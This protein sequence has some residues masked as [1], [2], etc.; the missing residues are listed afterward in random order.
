MYFQNIETIEEIYFTPREIDIISCITNVRGIKKI[1]QILSISPRTVEGHIQNILL[2]ISSNS[3]ESIK[4]FIEKSEE[5]PLVKQHYLDLIINSF[6]E[7]QLNKLIPLFREAKI[8]CIVNHAQR[9]DILNYIIKYLKRVGIETIIDTSNDNFPITTQDKCTILVLNQN[10]ILELKKNKNYKNIIF[11]CTEEG[12]NYNVLH[13]FSD[14]QVL[15]FTTK[16]KI[17]LG[18]F[19]ILQILAPNIDF[20]DSIFKFNKMY[21]NI[22]NLKVEIN[23]PCSE[24]ANHP[25]SLNSSDSINYLKQNFIKKPL[26]AIFGFLCIVMLVSFVIVNNPTYNKYNEVVSYNFGLPNKNILLTRENI[27]KKIDT[28]FKRIND[29]TTVVLIGN[30]G[31]GKTTIARQYALTHKFSVLWEVNAETKNSLMTSLEQLVYALSNSIEERQ[32]LNQLLEIKNIEKRENQL[33]LLAQ[34]KLK[35]YPDWLIIY[36]NVESFKN[37][38][39]YFPYNKAAWGDGRIIITTR[40]ANFLNNSIEASNMIQVT[41]LND[42]EK[43][44]L[45]FNIIEEKAE[46]TEDHKS[47]S[48]NEKDINNF[49]SKIPSY[50]LDV[51]VAAYYIKNTG[52]QFEEYLKYISQP[53]P[54][55]EILQGKILEDVSE[56]SKTRYNIIKLSLDQI[57]N[58]NPGFKDLLL[59]VAL[60]DSQDIPIELLFSLK[61]H[62]TVNSFIS[63]LKKNFFI[64]NTSFVTHDS[65]EKLSGFSIHRNAQLVTLVYLT[66]ILKIQENKELLKSIINALDQYASYLTEIEDT[67]K[68]QILHKHCEALKLKGNSMLEEEAQITLEITMGDILQYLG[69]DS[70]AQDTLEKVIVAPNQNPIKI[71]KA[72][73]SL[74]NIYRRLGNYEKAEEAFKKSL[75]IYEGLPDQKIQLA[76]TSMYLGILYRLNGNA[77]KAEEAFKKSLAVSEGLPNQKIQLAKTSMYLGTFYRVIGDLQAAK[78]LLEQSFNIYSEYPQNNIGYA[79]ISAHLGVLYSTIKEYDKAQNLLESSLNIYNKLRKPEHIDIAW[80]KGHLGSLYGKK[81][82]IQEGIKLIEDSLE[83]YKKHFGESH[84]ETAQVMNYLAELYILSNQDNKAEEL[85]LKA[86]EIFKVKKHLG[87]YYS[88]ELL[89]DLYSQKLNS[90]NLQDKSKI[91]KDKAIAYFESALKIATKNFDSNSVNILRLQQ[92]LQNFI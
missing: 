91:Y 41:E 61:D 90:N 13:E 92:K 87:E 77:Q 2:K 51:S 89:G 38:Q 75:A 10:H 54:Q 28:S 30:G 34:K 5:L 79:R 22:V 64:T 6:F 19:K 46:E 58:K 14:I 86:A 60:L 29:I 11:I 57:I 67:S 20:E 85:A 16:E 39:P 37:I 48:Y 3:Q 63:N 66:S 1:A 31:S 76:K 36:D 42:K 43:L 23:S 59:F 17:H 7:Q 80:V 26:V 45:F 53:D 68:L 8:K 72:Y 21:R 9:N 65:R 27:L 50:P 56:Y 73:S 24:P 74:G 55:F 70:E 52:M 62:L 82:K 78:K 47:F 12:L 18:I 88:L 35:E 4:D 44:Q 84:T 49:L 83:I 15:D 33:L 71:A 25:S 69:Y 40:D 81:G 32:E